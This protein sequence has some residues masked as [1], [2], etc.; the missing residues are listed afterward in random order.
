MT[1]E[2][3]RQ[4]GQFMLY[5]EGISYGPFA[6]PG[7]FPAKYIMPG[8]S[9]QPGMRME[10][11]QLAFE[12]PEDDTTAKL[13]EP[14]G[15]IHGVHSG[16]SLGSLA[17]AAGITFSV[18][19][20]PTQ[21][22]L[23]RLR[24]SDPPGVPDPSLAPQI[25]G[26]YNGLSAA[27]MYYYY[28]EPQENH[29]LFDL[30]DAFIATAKANGLPVHCHHLIGGSDGYTP[31][32][33]VD[34]NFTKDQLTQILVNH[35]TTLVSHYKG[36]CRSWDVVNEALASDGSLRTDNVW[37]KG[38]GPTYIDLAFQTAHDADPQSKLYYNEYD[39]ENMTP[40]ADGVYNLVSG[41]LQ[42][43]V[44]I[45]GVGLQSHWN[46]E[47][48]EYTPH[49]DQLV[50]NMAR[51]AKLGLS[52]RIS[53]LDD[54]IKLPATLDDFAI[55]ATAFSTTVKA[56][57]DSPNCVETTVWDADDKLSWINFFFPGY[58]V[59]TMFDDALHPKPA[60]TA[61]LDTLR[62]A[63]KAPSAITEVHTASGGTDIAQNTFIEIK[64]VNL[65]PDT[66]PPAGVI[67]S[68]APE[69][70]QGRMP[71]KLDDVSV[72]V[73]GKPAFIYFY[74]SA[75]TSPSCVAD[76]INVLTP[77]DDTVGPV[78]IVVTSGNAVSTAFTVNMQAVAPTFLLFNPLGPVVSTHTDY[79][80]A[81]ALNLYPG[82]STPAK[83]GETILF[84]AVGFGLPADPLT[85][86]SSSQFGVLPSAPVCQVGGLLADVSAALISP[87][88][89]QLN[90]T[91]PTG[92]VSGDLPVDCTYAGATTHPGPFLTVQ[93]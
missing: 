1:F 30:G 43:G 50:A 20:P 68:N 41:M 33:V 82:Y 90:L 47:S 91:I 3:L 9:V 81:G 77:L 36:Q 42:R 72:T 15:L 86:G 73:N 37:A 57:L 55:Q 64:G 27:T 76:Q 71:E 21:L 89:Y 6:D 12:V 2:L 40:K 17:A 19:V 61:V 44:P 60:Y 80:L 45:D 24:T 92:A 88:L 23:G 84:Y 53:E 56:C 13:V 18:E 93:Q 8:I 79:S 34:G 16:D 48:D 69:F 62:A 26:Q 14:I 58:G 49:Y 25:L 5:F 10:L 52:V 7:L 78:Q 70:A 65:V 59:A 4:N 66:T 83:P 35:V 67:W 38:I 39:S 46:P 32:W 29:F 51:L 54:R 63:P 87:G 31:S 22:S 75:A 28:T 85:N 11:T 74:C